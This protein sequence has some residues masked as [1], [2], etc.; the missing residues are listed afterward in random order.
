MANAN[1]ERPIPL[2]E[3]DRGSREAASQ[4]LILISNDMR[5]GSKGGFDSA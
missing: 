3:R 2:I 4:S 1:A 5:T